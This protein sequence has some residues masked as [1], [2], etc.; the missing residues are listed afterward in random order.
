MIPSQKHAPS[1]APPM[2]GGGRGRFVYAAFHWGSTSVAPTP[3]RTRR[4]NPAPCSSFRP[5]DSASLSLRIY[6]ADTGPN[7]FFWPV[8]PRRLRALKCA[9]PHDLQSMR[10]AKIVVCSI[11]IC[12]A[13]GGMLALSGCAL[14]GGSAISSQTPPIS[15]SASYY[16]WCGATGAGNGSEWMDAYTALPS[17]LV[18]GATYYIAGSRSC[19]YGPHIFND[20]ISGTTLITIL[21]STAANSG[22]V[23]GWQASFGTT[24]AQFTGLGSSNDSIWEF[25]KS[26]YYVDGI[27]GGTPSSTTPPVAGTFGFYLYEAPCASPTCTSTGRYLYVASNPLNNTQTTGWLTFKHLEMY[28]GPLDTNPNDTIECCGSGPHLDT[29]G[30]I[31]TNITV[32]DCYIHDINGATLEDAASNSLVDH[33]WLEVER[34]TL[35]QHNEAMT[36]RDFV[37]SNVTISNNTFQDMNGTGGIVLIEIPGVNGLYIYN[38][39]FFT[40]SP[41]VMDYVPGDS[42][43]NGTGL[44]AWNFAQGSAL[45]NNA[46]SANYS[47]IYVFNNTIYSTSGESSGIQIFPTTAAYDN[48]N[49]WNNLWV[50]DLNVQIDATVP[51]G[52]TGTVTNFT[53]S[54]NVIIDSTGITPLPN[55]VT[56]DICINNAFN[57]GAAVQISS[58]SIVRSVVTVTTVS[59]H[60]LSV[61]SPA[62]VIGTD[63]NEG[64]CGADTTYPYPIVSAVVSP[65]VFQ[66]TLPP[67]AGGLVPNVTICALDS[68]GFVITTP[69]AMPFNSPADFDFQL[70]TSSPLFDQLNQGL[71]LTSTCASLG[72]NCS[73][74]NGVQRPLNGSW[75]VGAYQS[76]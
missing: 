17:S 66:Y 74:P 53:E 1:P 55:C 8:E 22:S 31:F 10:G 71:N 5:S 56:N 16:V 25:D 47:N 54:N 46:E 41:T 23:A 34:H 65:T 33:N 4:P 9:G 24:P 48:I 42:Q 59:P 67:T 39:V 57:S 63:L 20:A 28:N 14:G 45:A 51:T 15:P 18:R 44:P 27:T 64:A 52:A 21:K 68:A 73:D 49:I 37:L 70:S 62:V 76:Q 50:H 61:G 75:T 11:A 32:Q 7:P 19:T 35:A 30:E 60:G 58:A 12:P 26:Y 3:M 36:V 29:N 13:L 40:S 43:V 38:N 69:S 72:L 6:L 2:T